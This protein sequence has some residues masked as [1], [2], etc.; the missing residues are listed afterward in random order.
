MPLLPDHRFLFGAGVVVG[1]AVCGCNADISLGSW[2]TASEGEGPR[3]PAD[4][5]SAPAPTDQEPT[6]VS[7]EPPVP[8]DDP[9]P[10]DEDA[11]VSVGDAGNDVALDGGASEAGAPAE[12]QGL[13]MCM[14][15]GDSA[16]LS[17]SGDQI[18]STVTYTDWSWPAPMSSVEFDIMVETET[19]NETVVWSYQF[20]FVAGIAGLLGLQDQGLYQADPPDGAIVSSKIAMFWISGP[21]LSAELGDVSYPDARTAAEFSK[22]LPWTSIHV[23]FDWE[24]CRAYRFR[25]ALESTGPNGNRWYG[26]WVTDPVDDTTTFL[27]RMLVPAAWGELSAFSSVWTDRFSTA[28]TTTCDA[29]EYSSAIFGAPVG[30][31]GALRPGMTNSRFE[32]PTRCPTSRITEFTAAVRHE[33]GVGGD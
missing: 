33:L 1:C 16:M 29:I 30:D 10:S 4:H 32:D 24:P 2:R 27:G 18:A 5:P 20:S 26:A 21:P 12:P 23:R 14:A 31:D 28:P 9:P 7:P 15:A 25:L 8:D 11:S 19:D 6:S 22:G 3:V 13:P 17:A